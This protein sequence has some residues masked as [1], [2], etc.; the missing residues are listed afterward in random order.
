M[1]SLQPSASHGLHLRARV[2]FRTRKPIS[3]SV[4]LCVR[5]RLRV[6]FRQLS[7][8][9]AL[10]TK[11]YVYVTTSWYNIYVYVIV[12]V[13]VYVDAQGNLDSRRIRRRA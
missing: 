12:H 6:Q 4:E 1:S 2:R 13:D 11:V 8:Q 3:E 9:G 5:R 7:N 10:E